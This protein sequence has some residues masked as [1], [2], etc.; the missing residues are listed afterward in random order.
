MIFN[1]QFKLIMRSCLCKIIT[2]GVLFAFHIPAAASDIKIYLDDTRTKHIM[3]KKQDCSV[4]RSENGKISLGFKAGTFF[5][6]IGPE[7]SFDK[8]SGID[9]DTLTQKVVVKYLELCTRFNTGSISKSEYEKRLKRIEDIEEAAY[10]LYQKML[11]E[12][13]NRK[14]QIFKELDE[15][16]KQTVPQ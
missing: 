6:G 15:E 10:K 7:F 16:T 1:Y 5:F 3:V 2:I 11:E 9:W 8:E 14:D 4:Y 12:I 13:A